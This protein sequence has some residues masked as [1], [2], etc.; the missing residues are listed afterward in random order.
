MTT[1]LHWDK[2]KDMIIWKAL[3][4]LYNLFIEIDKNP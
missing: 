4:E 2:N 3:Y 1:E